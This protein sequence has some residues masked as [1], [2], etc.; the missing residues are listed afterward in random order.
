MARVQGVDARI[1]TWELVTGFEESLAPENLLEYFR[2]DFPE[3]EGVP[4]FWKMV[5]FNS[6]EGRRHR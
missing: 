2:R 1:C 5:S 3:V 6:P 4:K